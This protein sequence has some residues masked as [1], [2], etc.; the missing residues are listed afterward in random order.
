MFRFV[1]QIFVLAMMFLGCNV[2]VVNSLNAV[3]KCILMNNQECKIRP[4]IMN[5]DSNEPLFYPYSIKVNKYCGSCNDPYSKLCVADVV[6]IMNFKV[7]NL[8]S[9]TN[10]T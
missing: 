10:E 9:S 3:Q 2:S 7:F 8:M 4:E 6:K 1:K 5:I